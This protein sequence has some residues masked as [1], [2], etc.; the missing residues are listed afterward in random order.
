MNW[1]TKNSKMVIQ[2]EGAALE[3]TKDTSAERPVNQ[4]LDTSRF[5][6][7]NIDCIESDHTLTYNDEILRQRLKLVSYREAKTNLVAKNIVT[8][9]RSINRCAVSEISL[10]TGEGRVIER[11]KTAFMDS[12][13]LKTF[14]DD[15]QT[16]WKPDINHL[17]ARNFKITADAE[18]RAMYSQYVN[19]FGPQRGAR[20]TYEGDTRY[21]DE[22]ITPHIVKVGPRVA[23]VEGDLMSETRSVVTSGTSD[24]DTNKTDTDDGSKKRKKK[25][26]KKRGKK[27]KRKGKRRGKRKGKKKGK[28]KGKKKKRKKK[29]DEEDEAKDKEVENSENSK[30]DKSDKSKSESKVKKRKKRNKRKKKKVKKKKSE[31]TDTEDHTEGDEE[32]V[33]KA[34]ESQ[35]SKSKGSKSKKKRKRKK[36]KR[37]KKRKGKKTKKKKPGM[38]YVIME[39]GNP[40]SRAASSSSY[41]ESQDSTSSSYLDAFYNTDSSDSTEETS[42]CETMGSTTATTSS[43]GSGTQTSSSDEVLQNNIISKISSRIQPVMEN[44][45]ATKMVLYI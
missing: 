13:E 3:N 11:I 18:F 21:G 20:S 12:P 24:K 37:K 33:K 17:D 1:E 29:K 25:T 43:T 34:E 14:E 19:F 15:W 32:E 45:G 8:K 31:K 42:S 26:K 4:T 16:L 30:S 2:Y 27:G 39:V 22:L 7:I 9:Y 5:Q 6:R 44:F 28:R 23:E 40:T 36:N 10:Q 35:K 41:T 38:S